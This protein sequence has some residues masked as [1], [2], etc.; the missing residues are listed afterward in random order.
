MSATKLTDD[1]S[2]RRLV[3]WECQHDNG[4]RTVI[5]EQ[6]DGSFAA[7]ALGD[8]PAGVDYVDRNIAHAHAA[9]LASLRRKSGHRR[10][11]DEC[12]DWRVYPVDGTPD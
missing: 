7:A 3:R 9:V 11:S 8:L 12:S 10:C 1:T 6:S 5:A 2:R 4:W